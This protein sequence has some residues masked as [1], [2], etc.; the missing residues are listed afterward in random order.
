MR[1]RHADSL[2]GTTI[3][4]SIRLADIYY[5]K[6]T[7]DAGLFRPLA[8]ALLTLRVPLRLFR[9]PARKQMATTKNDI[10]FE[11]GESYS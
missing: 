1:C 2:L 3:C 11:S 9:F 8:Q 10:L 4:R 6:N 7:C 5:L